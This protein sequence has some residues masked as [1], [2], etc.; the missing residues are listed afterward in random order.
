MVL[1]YFLL[2]SLVLIHHAL[3]LISRYLRAV[4]WDV[5]Q[6]SFLFFSL[7]LFGRAPDWFELRSHHRATQSW[8]KIAKK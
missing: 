5:V 2:A 3:F 1:I 6:R 4:V 8:S 7:L